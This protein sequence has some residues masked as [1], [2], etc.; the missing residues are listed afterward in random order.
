MAYELMLVLAVLWAAAYPFVALTDYPHA[1][2]LRPVYRLF[3]AGVM[4][5]YFLG[6]WLQGG[7]TL[8]MKTWNLRL[9]AADGRRL[10]ATRALLRFVL[11]TLGL[12]FCGVTI[13]WAFLDHDRQFLHDRLAGTRLI[14]AR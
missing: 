14:L 6:F 8:A 11:A 3:L 1:S 9:V 12:A 7:Q 4:L 2:H 5:A 13:L 10:T